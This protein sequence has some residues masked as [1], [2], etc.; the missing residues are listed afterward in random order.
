MKKFSKKQENFICQVCGAL[1]KGDGYTDHCF[2]CLWGKHVDINPGDRNCHCLGLME[3]IG[4]V[5]K[6]GE[7]RIK[8]KC[9]KCGIIKENRNAK[10]D[11]LGKI[12]EL[13]GFGF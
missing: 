9:L 1:I 12:I 13:S 3:P 2:R 5:K 4:A 10:N 11:N 7:W 8:Y 6:K